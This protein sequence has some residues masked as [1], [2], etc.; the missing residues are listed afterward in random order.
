MRN[1]RL[2]AALLCAALALTGCLAQPERTGDGSQDRFIGLYVM[3]DLPGA[4]GSAIRGSFYD[5]PNLTPYGRENLA[6]EGIG[7]VSLDREVLFAEQNSAGDYFFPGMEGGCALLLYDYEGEDGRVTATQNDMAPGEDGGGTKI[8]VTDEGEENS[9]SGT[10]YVGPPLGAGDDWNT[11]EHQQEQVIWTAYRVYQTPDGRVYTDG[12]GDSYGGPGFSTTTTDTR[13]ETVDGESKTC[14]LSVTL[15][16]REISRL[17][18]V[19]LRQFDGSDQLLRTDVVE[20]GQTEKGMEPL[21]LPLDPGAAYVLATL[22][23]A[24][25]VSGRELH[26]TGQET[27]DGGLDLTFYFL[28]EAGMGYA[29]PVNL[30]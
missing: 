23:S 10:V 26:E 25:G 14:S 16:V 27:G 21:S 8:K 24:G 7:P 1:K 28:D 20:A 9:I 17:E 11:W 5:N 18:A 2:F 13:T 29:V 30:K 6:V 19:T 15:A 22:S 4:P 3:G 12:S